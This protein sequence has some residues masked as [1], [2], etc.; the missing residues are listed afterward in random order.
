MASISRVTIHDVAREA[1]VSIA[2]VSRVLNGGRTVNRGMA[3]K[4][5]EVAA[6]IGYLPNAAA[7]G[8]VSGRFRTIGVVV[9]DLANQYFPEVLR[10]AVLS[11]KIDAYRV[12][13]ID[14]M[15]E[16][17]EEYEAC[18]QQLP[19]VDG[20]ILLSPRMSDSHMAQ[21]A[22][23]KIPLVVVNRVVESLDLPTITADNRTAIHE[24]CRHLHSHGHRTIVHVSSTTPTWQSREREAA[25]AESAEALGF[26]LVS[27]RANQ[28]IAGGHDS[29]D[30]VLH[31]QAT[32]VVAFN[33]LM[34][35]GIVSRL[36]ELGIRVP[37]DMSV[38]GFDDIDVARFSTPT[39]TT[40]LSPKDKLGRRAWE[41]MR[42]LLGGGEAKPVA[43]VAAPV[44]I[45]ESTGSA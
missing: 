32:A 19:N 2:T 23:S 7:R 17:D 30:A 12:V 34:A 11:A 33:D 21:L 18:R 31:H 42:S 40:A 15:G 26:E 36:T 38:A 13:V 16:A 45:R 3:E 27:M 43:P 24:I 20:L 35:F 9:P 44:I 1:Q 6:R 10:A 37:E 28:G 25:M 29:V 5:R 41:A 39:L 22:E 4:V 14:S 8:L